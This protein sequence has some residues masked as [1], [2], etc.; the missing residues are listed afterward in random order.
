MSAGFVHPKK[1]PFFKVGKGMKGLVI[2][3]FLIMT[4]HWESYMVRN[5]I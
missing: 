5:G 4:V 2:S 3:V 1:L